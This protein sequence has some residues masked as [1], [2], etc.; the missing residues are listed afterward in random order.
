MRLSPVSMT[1]S[2]PSARSNPRAS[3]VESLTGSATQSNPA[4]APSSARNMTVWPSARSCASTLLFQ[5]AG[6]N[7]ELFQQLQIAEC[8]ASGLPQRR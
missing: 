2:T 1:I 8:D 6:I 5:G 7:G 4:A 3:A